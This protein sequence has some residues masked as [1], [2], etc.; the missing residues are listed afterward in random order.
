MFYM[1]SCVPEHLVLSNLQ[2]DKSLL[3]NHVRHLELSLEP[4]RTL[5]VLCSPNIP[6]DDVFN[7]SVN[8]A[9]V[10]PLS[11]A[12]D[13]TKSILMTRGKPHADVPILSW[14]SSLPNWS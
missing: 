3:Q 1:L 5:L 14:T 10:V 7:E 12:I 6:L 9:N 11:N 13:T 2:P 8:Q 4:F